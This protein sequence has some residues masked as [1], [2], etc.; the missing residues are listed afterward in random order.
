MSN[1]LT[2]TTTAAYKISEVLKGII[3]VLIGGLFHYG[4]LLNNEASIFLF[5][6]FLFYFGAILIV[7]L[8]FT[9]KIEID[10]KEI[11]YYALMNNKYPFNDLKTYVISQ[12]M[13]FA[14]WKIDTVTKSPTLI[15]YKKD[16]ISIDIDLTGFSHDA[17]SK[18]DN[19]LKRELTTEK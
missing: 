13:S 5:F 11:A 17:F 6:P 2:V 1:D 10:S 14:G 15:L 3:L 18:I 8:G 16:N 12:S 7:I 4:L 9:K 19:I